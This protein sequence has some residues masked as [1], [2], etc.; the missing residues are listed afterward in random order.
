M[1]MTLDR[2]RRVLSDMLRYAD[3]ITKVVRRGR[4]EFFDPGDVRNRAT[5]EHYLELLGEASEAVGQSVHTTNPDI[6]WRVLRRL[7][8]DRAHPYDPA[9]ERVNFDELWRFATLELPKIRRQLRR[10]KLPRP[11]ESRPA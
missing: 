5:I 11:D 6:P 2:Q 1:K 7:R 4:E 10:A 9:A 8:F 3:E